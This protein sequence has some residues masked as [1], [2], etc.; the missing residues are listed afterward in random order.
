MFLVYGSEKSLKNP[1]LAVSVAS[2]IDFKALSS[3][4]DAALRKPHFL[5][6]LRLS[7]S[8]TS[9]RELHRRTQFRYAKMVG[10][11]ELW[12]CEVAQA[13]AVALYVN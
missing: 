12:F 6:A 1:A 13:K 5:S 7:S 11:A 2:T 10:G 9:L 4:I 8:K 3:S